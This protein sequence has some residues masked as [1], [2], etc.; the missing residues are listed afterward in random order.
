MEKKKKC[1]KYLELLLL[2]CFFILSASVTVSA[3]TNLLTS[4]KQAKEGT[5]QRNENGRKYVYSNGRHP[6]SRWLK[7]KGKY[8][9]FDA[10]GYAETGW[11]DYNGS[12]YY[13]SEVRGKEGQLLFGLQTVKG[14]TYYLSPTTGQL[15][16][17]WQTIGNKRYYFGMKIGAMHK[18]Q[19]IGS[20]YVSANGSVTK[21]RQ[22][23]KSRLI[24]L[25]DCRVASMRDC[26][27]GNAIYI[28]KVS[29]GYNWLK[30][31]AG[32]MLESYLASYPE[33]T[34]VF[35]FGLNDYLYQQAKYIAY[36]RSFIASHPNVNIYLMSINP[37]IGVGAYN[38]SNATI[39][40]FNKALRNNF[41]NNYLDC[42]SH[43][44]K[45]GYYAADGQHYD[46][47]TYRKIYNYI[48][49]ATGW[50]S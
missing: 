3:G 28:G 1:R 37:V 43:L 24:I 10:S 33:S 45:V 22:T 14:K 20:R 23:S 41:P 29:M 26:K 21:V 47:A 42:F 4:I 12:R 11:K 2:M 31:T 34:V 16:H 13:L 46:T 50:V 17:G 35:G 49:K 40:P 32:P 19:W 7:I 25:G 5:W 6:K 18:K 27:I 9:S 38:V 39:T 36:Y 44:Q 48:V 15:L 30:S 8:Y